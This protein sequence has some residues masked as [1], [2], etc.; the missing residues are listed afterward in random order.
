[1][2]KKTI[3]YSDLDGNPIEEDFYFHLNMAEI[4]KM[5][6]GTDGGLAAKL[7]K[8]AKAAN[9]RE[10]IDQFE[11]VIMGAYGVRSED[12]KRFIKTKEVKD[13]F[14]ESDAYSELFMELI[15]GADKAAE[16]VK[17]ILPAGFEQEVQRLQDE[18]TKSV[19]SNVFETNPSEPAQALPYS[20]VD[21]MN[22]SAEEFAALK[23][24]QR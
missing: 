10:I 3:K 8:L 2:L 23:A 5:E 1:M 9:G 21:I 15:S 12:N 20:A 13:A 22:M 24:Q 7:Q 11:A 19:S 4:S 14:Y 6:L 17:G 16:F 18:K